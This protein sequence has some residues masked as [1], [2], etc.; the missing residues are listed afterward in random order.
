VSPLNDQLAVLVEAAQ[1]F[2]HGLGLGGH[3]RNQIF[4]GLWN[5]A[6]ILD[7]GIRPEKI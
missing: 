6:S 5:L 1:L 7:L 4:E 3:G 2:S